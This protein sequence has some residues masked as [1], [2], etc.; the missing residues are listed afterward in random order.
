MAVAAIEYTR[1]FRE[2]NQAKICIK[3]ADKRVLDVNGLI[4]SIEGDR[5]TLELVGSEPVEEI[6]AEPDTSVFITFWTGWSLCRCNAVLLQKVYGRRVY[7]R[8]TGQVIE[9]QT[10]EYFRLDVSIP[11]CYTIP[12][13]QLL[14]SVHEDWVATRELMQ[15]LAA[16]LLAACPGGFKVVRWH[17]QGEILPR[18][19]NLSAG[20]L[21]FKTPEYFP[22]Q[23]LVAISL[24]L[25][26]V[27]P[28]VIHTVAETLRC[29]EIVLSH[30]RGN[31]YIT[32]ARFHFI[33]DKDRETII[34]FIFAEQRRFL[35]ASADKGFK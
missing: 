14:A 4:R 28:R 5:L 31:N 12:G 18:P 1:Y 16:P 17:G 9:K 8:L 24:F 22:P 32:A 19:V 21:R 33:S 7:L 30:E 3:L 34:A 26:L 2:D 29:S 27:P 35:N 25:P 20:G 23:S 11:L 15:G 6:T 13:Q 10:R